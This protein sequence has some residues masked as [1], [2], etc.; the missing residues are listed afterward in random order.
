[1]PP[2][3]GDPGTVLRDVRTRR[4]WYELED[5]H[6]GMARGRLAVI[7]ALALVAAVAPLDMS[8]AERAAAVAACAV[9][10]ALHALLAWLPAR[11]PSRLLLAVDVGLVV[12]AAL[13]LVLARA[14]GGADS[15][16][17]WLLPLFCLAVT[18]ALGTGQ[19]VKALILSALVVGA[20]TAWEGES[21]STLSDSA[22]PLAMAVAV[23]A[24]AGVLT[25]LNERQLEAQRARLDTLHT[26]SVA[27]VG[28]EDAESVTDAA[29]AGARGLLPGWDVAVRLGDEPVRERAWREDGR[30]L[31]ELPLEAP[32]DD[33]A[34]ARPLGAITG[35]RPLAGRARAVVRRETVGALRT[36]ARDASA[37]LVQ[38]EL[39][40]GLERLS[41]SDPLTS[42]GNRRAFDEALA[43]EM[44]RARRSG[45]SMGVVILD[46]NHFKQFND[47]HGHQAGDDA[48]VSVAR[49]LAREARAEDRACRIGGEEF[50]LLL[51]GADDAAA[52]TVA[53]RIR[54]AVEDSADAA[55][56]LTVSLGV[57]ASRGD[58]AR[59]L[60]ATAD[61]R[62]YVAKEAGRNR[63]ISS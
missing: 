63:V 11:H 20:L 1:M 6:A 24:I 14:S 5:R 23:V 16:A 28:A 34:P 9:A 4:D 57:A 22:G 41:L 60:L 40:E 46:V 37:A 26:A 17:V 10:A 27:L 12:D 49:V 15:L 21:A 33:G 19:G 25:R 52:A 51:P 56:G 7:A 3:S 45:G 31:L 47:R 58:D 39:R 61:A 53:E 29:A 48:L 38:V 55:E 59:G 36:L 13:V 42:L 43:A 18:L 8:G 50:A 44:A 62:L 32:A 54:R 30:A 2:T 35:S